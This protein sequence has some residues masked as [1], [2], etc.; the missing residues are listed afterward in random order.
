[1]NLWRLFSFFLLLLASVQA[2]KAA[3]SSVTVAEFC[4][5][6]VDSR[7]QPSASQSSEVASGFFTEIRL[8]LDPE[9]FVNVTAEMPNV[10][11]RKGKGVII[12][13]LGAVNADDQNARDEIRDLS[14]QT[15]AFQEKLKQIRVAPDVASCEQE[16]A[17]LGVT[18][19][20]LSDYSQTVDRASALEQGYLSEY[21][22]ELAQEAGK[23]Y[24]RAEVV[25]LENWEDAQDFIQALP[26]GQYDFVFV[27]HADAE[28]RLFDH[29]MSV[30]V[31]FFERIADRAAS[32]AIFSCFP[33][34]V[35]ARY[36]QDVFSKYRALGIPVYQPELLGTFEDSQTTPIGLLDAFTRQES[37][38]IGI[39]NARQKQ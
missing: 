17:S 9:S 16:A 13:S 5:A 19:S 37:R 31:T 20:E 15:Q 30:M 12:F 28:G 4:K 25:A 26:A 32:V 35:R 6:A 34:K 10:P 22:F 11:V 14:Q 29:A 24:G 38:M 7:A 1:M 36:E 27:F 2:A 39:D 3:E 21:N 18:D 23:E 8:L 33:E